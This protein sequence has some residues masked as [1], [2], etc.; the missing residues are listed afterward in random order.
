MDK[1]CGPD[2]FSS[3]SRCRWV[4]RVGIGEKMPIVEPTVSL[5]SIVGMLGMWWAWQA[6]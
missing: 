6:M 3:R 2:G 1:I 5:V 4:E